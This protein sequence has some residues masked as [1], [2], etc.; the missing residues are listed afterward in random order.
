[1]SGKDKGTRSMRKDQPSRR[2]RHRLAQNDSLRESL[3]RSISR[4]KKKRRTMELMKITYADPEVPYQIYSQNVESLN[5]TVKN[6]LLEQSEQVAENVEPNFSMM[7]TQNISTQG[8]ETFSALN[9]EGRDY[10]STDSKDIGKI[11][12]C[13]SRKEKR[14]PPTFECEEEA[15]QNC[16]DKENVPLNPFKTPIQQKLE[17][18]NLQENNKNE[19]RKGKTMLPGMSQDGN[20]AKNM[21]SP[22]QNDPNCNEERKTMFKAT[23]YSKEK[24]RFMKGV[25]FR[26][27]RPNTKVVPFK[28]SKSNSSTT[29]HHECLEAHSPKFNTHV[30]KVPRTKEWPSNSKAPNRRRS[31]SLTYDKKHEGL[32]EG[33]RV[34]FNVKPDGILMKSDDKPEARPQRF[35]ETIVESTFR[36][37]QIGRQ[38]G[39]EKGK[40]MRIRDFLLRKP[41]SKPT[42]PVEPRLHTDKRSLEREEYAKR[43]AEYRKELF[44]KQ[45]EDLERR[46][47]MRQKNFQF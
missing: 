35:L 9:F 47:K 32:E 43:A 20:F 30:E 16:E 38:E 33:Y 2:F 23:P 26:P 24:I 3:C 21:I 14:L 1:M 7:N 19:E 25:P 10:I 46:T 13:L 41:V 45:R 44:K 27:K 15:L 29:L 22:T 18:L 39:E 28:L 34:T 4:L 17:K 42:V 8:K 31:N 40:N 37:G 11:S 5:S 36:K 6:G 12:K